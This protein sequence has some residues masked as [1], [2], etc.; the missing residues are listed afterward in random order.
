MKKI[1]LIN[2]TVIETLATAQLDVTIN[3]RIF[4][5]LFFVILQDLVSI[6]LGRSALDQIQPDWRNILNQTQVNLTDNTTLSNDSHIMD[7]LHMMN[8][9]IHDMT[10]KFV[11]DLLQHTIQQCNDNLSSQLDIVQK[12]HALQTLMTKQ[13]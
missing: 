10:S 4:S 11:A 6:C 1:K 7:K 2:K 13:L 3:N 5:L 8:S 9:N 12:N